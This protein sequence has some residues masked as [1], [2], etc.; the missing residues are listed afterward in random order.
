MQV[1]MDNYSSLVSLPLLS[2]IRFVLLNRLVFQTTCV[3]PFSHHLYAFHS[4]LDLISAM[5]VEKISKEKL[6]EGIVQSCSVLLF[7]NDVRALSIALS[8]LIPLS[9]AWTGDDV[10]VVV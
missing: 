9:L 10:L 3:S 7:L 4:T 6:S 8:V 1:R 2:A 5:C